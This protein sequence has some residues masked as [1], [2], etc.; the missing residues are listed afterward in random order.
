MERQGFDERGKTGAFGCSRRGGDEKDG[1]IL[2]I[3]RAQRKSIGENKR[4]PESR[5]RG[6]GAA[7]DSEDE[8]SSEVSSSDSAGCP[9]VILEGVGGASGDGTELKESDRNDGGR[10][11]DRPGGSDFFGASQGNQA[12]FEDRATCWPIRSSSGVRSEAEPAEEA[13]E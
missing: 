7:S 10:D 13:E 2:L 8:D 11:C 1:E 9:E 12:F 6:A 4:L 5:L 3:V